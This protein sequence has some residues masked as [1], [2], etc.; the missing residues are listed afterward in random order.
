M[1]RLLGQVHVRPIHAVTQ[2]QSGSGSVASGRR[3]RSRLG[4]HGW[5]KAQFLIFNII[6]IEIDTF[7]GQRLKRTDFTRANC[8]TAARVWCHRISSSGFKAK[9]WLN[10]IGPPC[11]ACRFAATTVAP[12]A[13]RGTC[14]AS[15]PTIIHRLIWPAAIDLVIRLRFINLQRITNSSNSKVCLISNRFGPTSPSI[16]VSPTSKEPKEKK[17]RFPTS[18]KNFYF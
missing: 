16:K 13:Y 11:W 2:R 15:A 7:L 6:A 5:G 1:L 3:L 4:Q 14:W 18:E 9:I 8:W 12:P 17:I 10:S